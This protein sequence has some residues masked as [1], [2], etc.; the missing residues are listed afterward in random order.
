MKR[1]T[2]KIFYFA[3]LTIVLVAMSSAPQAKSKSGLDWYSVKGDV[4]KIRELQSK[5]FDLTEASGKSTRDGQMEAGLVLS[6]DEVNA[7]KAD[8]YTVVLKK[9]DQGR[10]ASEEA[11]VQASSGFSVWKPYDGKQG[12]HKTYVKIAQERRNRRL[13]KLKV[14]GY[15]LQGREILAMRITAPA[16]KKKK[17]KPESLPEKPAV[18]Y[19]A[20]AHAREWITGEVVLRTANYF[21][22]G[23]HSGDTEVMAILESTEIWILPVMNPD[24]YQFT[25]EP[26]GERFQRKNMRDTDNSGGYSP[27]DGVDLNRNAESHWGFDDEG[28]SSDPHNETYRGPH[29]A[30]EPETIAFQDFIKREK[31]VFMSNVHSVAN[32]I[33]YGQGYTTDLS[34]ADNPVYTALAGV[35]DNSAI[36]GFDPGISSAELYGV[37]GVYGDFV[38]NNGGLSF[39]PEMSDGGSG[40]GFVFPDNETL[41]QAEFEKILPFHLSLAKSA[42]D[43]ANPV[44]SVGIVTRPFYL[45]DTGIDTEN[46]ALTVMDFDFEISYRG[47]QEVRVRAQRALGAI[48]VKYRI[49]GGSEQSAPTSEW[50]GGNFYDQGASYS[51]AV[52][53]GMVTGAG[54]GDSVE[55]W[56]EGGGQ[57]SDH[58]SYTVAANS[59]ASVLIIANEDYSAYQFEM[60][61]PP[62]QLNY[63][64]YYT[65]ALDSLGV[66]YDVYDIDA[67]GH[68]PPHYLGVMS[69]YDAII[70][71]TGESL[72]STEP[73]WGVDNVFG[74]FDNGVSR[75]AVVLTNSIRDF[76]NEGG[77]VFLS[78]VAAGQQLS[79]N[80]IGA[81]FYD[82]FENLP[83]FDEGNHTAISSR[84]RLIQNVGDLQNDVLQYYFGSSINNVGSGYDPATDGAF[85]VI[86]Q[87][88][89][90]LEGISYT[91]NGDNAATDLG[92]PLGAPV[93]D[94]RGLAQSFVTTTDLLSL[95]A[96]ANSFP[97]FNSFA[98]GVYDTGE[99]G[100]FDPVSGDFM[101]FSQLASESY[102]RLS[103]TVSNLPAAAHLQF[104]VN[105]KT[106]IDWDYFIVE[107]H[108]VGNDDWTTLPDLNGHTSSDLS[109][110]GLCWGG[111]SNPADPVNAIH[112][113][114]AHYQTFINWWTPCLNTGT[115][116]QW[117]AAQGD[118]GGWVQFDHD[119]SAYQGQDIEVALTY[120]TDWG[121]ELFPGVF[122]DDVIITGVDGS[123]ESFETGLGEWTL[124]PAPEGSREHINNW[125]R[126][127]PL[128]ITEAAVIE[129]D[130][131]LYM[132]HAF[133]NISGEAKR[134]ELMEAIINF[135]VPSLISD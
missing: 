41:I 123:A 20:L 38:D 68:I 31:P 117:H 131:V 64:A 60:T 48:T 70:W 15:T 90:A 105:Y 75:D 120:V 93:T 108:T 10:T 115:T 118:S 46:G 44:S 89:T 132:G 129:T 124:P 128:G 32:L 127:G 80:L 109:N 11:I 50:G 97:L 133:E 74:P 27:G 85:P 54:V 59:S 34:A 69:H 5:G 73:G 6:V 92:T 56:F 25:H 61:G 119:L 28:S 96:P 114:L 99:G 23:Y 98:G 30:S 18:V 83:C 77:K 101:M 78:G 19:G 9:N 13:V 22:D 112:P 82:P 35:D 3:A 103:R 84:C 2:K 134:E 42:N 110:W 21:I 106:E 100:A 8:G 79:T 135:L 113:F 17:G 36:A 4:L 39:T 49:N 126:Q 62:G 57:A 51:Y 121:T 76:I 107:I 87:T 43:P 71:Y 26:Y 52:M 47:D 40:Q 24:S 67:Q 95:T 91:M 116:G 130:N 37:N 14:I 104:Y 53:T 1:I 55:V 102:K 33:L 81:G 58:F 66:E 125:I 12:L 63:L 72:V 94:F 122:I 88:G 7:L 16:P 65:D 45:N 29:A 86:G 111:G